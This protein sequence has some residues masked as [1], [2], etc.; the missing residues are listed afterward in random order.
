MSDTSGEMS[1]EDEPMP[2]LL[3]PAEEGRDSD[4]DDEGDGDDTDL[5]E[6]ADD[7][8]GSEDDEDEHIRG[9]P[10]LG[11]L[12]R[13]EITEIYSRRYEM[14][15]NELPRGPEYLPHVLTVQK[16]DRPDHFHLALHVSPNT[17]DRILEEISDDPVF[18]NNSPNGQLLIDEQLAIALYHFGHDGNAAS[19]Q[20]VA[21]WAGVGKGMV[22]LVTCHVM[23]AVLRPS[24]M[25]NAVWFPTAEEKNGAK[26]WVEVHSC[27]AWRHGW[28][29]V[30]GTSVPLSKRPTW[31][32]ESYFDRKC[33][34]SLN[35][36]V[37]FDK[38]QAPG[39]ELT[40][41]YKDCLLTQSPHY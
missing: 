9:V 32:G 3:G 25:S 19:L 12:I 39:L 20:H 26:A 33:N 21:N 1:D 13:A 27:H 7:E 16:H 24:F 38:L 8:G 41:I 35:I 23:T 22:T 17:F 15:C 6:N 40:I 5:G 30:D 29:L 36:Q 31:F 28:C 4:D 10:Y 34:Y 2:T 14:P 18:S 37:C 11:H